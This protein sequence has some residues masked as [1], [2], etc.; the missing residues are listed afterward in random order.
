MERLC[1]V[2]RQ[3]GNSLDFAE[4]LATLDCEL[5]LLLCY[6]ALSIHLVE[7][8]RVIPAYTAGADFQTLGSLELPL[9]SGVLGRVASTREPAFNCAPD[10]PGRLMIT[11]AVAIEY[12]NR[13]IGVLALYRIEPHVFASED[14]QVLTEI[15][16]KLAAS[17][18][19]ARR[20]QRI[21]RARVRAL[22]E[23]LDAEVARARRSGGR[24]AILECAVVA[25]DPAGSAA[26]QIAA[27]LR[28]LCREYDFVAHKGDAFVV[29]LADFGRADLPA[30]LSQ[31][32]AVFRGCGLT[33]TI[34]AALFPDDGSDA[35]DLL[36]AAH[37]T[38]HA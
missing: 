33:A 14:L 29:L 28:H 3:L 13:T 18:D 22:F 12:G 37:R 10:R 1:Q 17:M 35:E 31:I 34:G 20:F 15:V 25:L 7:D 21:E 8:G 32:E 30:K 23:R 5:R 4:T 6:D 36:T 9:A 16:P 19:N 24:L 2:F 27:D 11:M 38:A 26:E